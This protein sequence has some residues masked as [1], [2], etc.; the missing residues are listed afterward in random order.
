MPEEEFEGEV[1]DCFLLCVDRFTGWMIARPTRKAGL[2]GEKAAMLLWKD[3]WGEIGVPAVITTDQDP[4]FVSSFFST[5]CA[6]SGCRVVFSQ[7]HRPQANGR[8]ESAGK[9]IRDILR[10]L[11]LEEARN[12]VLL[13]PMAIRI[14]HD[15][16]D[17]E[18]GFSPYQLVFGRE[19]PGFGLPWAVPHENLEVQDWL[20]QREREEQELGD[21]L[22]KR[23]ADQ[24]RRRS[25]ERK[26][27]SFQKGDRVWLKRAKGITGPGLQPV[28]LGP[29]FIQR[30]VGENSF[31]LLMGRERHAVHTSQLK[32][33]V[34]TG[35]EG[36]LD[37]GSIIKPL[38]A[39]QA[40]GVRPAV[41]VTPSSPPPRRV[42]VAGNVT[43]CP[44]TQGLG[45]GRGVRRPGP[46]GAAGCVHP[47]E[48]L[49][50]SQP[51]TP[52]TP[53]PEGQPAEL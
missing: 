2:T 38:P 48:T 40:E 31:E 9:V 10:K 28:W 20:D 35:E 4:R 52:A 41:V 44:T 29:Y 5:M 8:A 16:V 53:A 45:K 47:S 51:A 42:P 21:K 24:A 14:R 1:Y 49:K 13:L 50:P 39:T 15:T 3:S 18:L 33:C 17:P 37:S 26:A 25:G 27:R 11:F 7:A 22:R 34:E 23:I 30:Q 6:L 36:L 12:W 46:A 43:P 19:R 32:L